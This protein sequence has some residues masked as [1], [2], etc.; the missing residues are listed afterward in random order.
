MAKQNAQNVPIMLCVNVLT[1]PATSPARDNYCNVHFYS[2]KDIKKLNISSLSYWLL[3]QLFEDIN[4][5]SIGSA[6]SD[7]KRNKQTDVAIAHI[8]MYCFNNNNN[9]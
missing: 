4:P 6:F 9:N 8:Y 7:F 2:Y 5:V 3:H 1:L